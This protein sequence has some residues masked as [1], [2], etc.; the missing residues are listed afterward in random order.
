MLP[1]MD[2]T[3][4]YVKLKIPLKCFKRKREIVRIKPRAFEASKYYFGKVSSEELD[5]IL[6]GISIYNIKESM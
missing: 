4:I 6:V 1:F 2:V 3:V 5:V